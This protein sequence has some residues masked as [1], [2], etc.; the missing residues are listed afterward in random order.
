MKIKGLLISL[1]AVPLLSLSVAGC[2]ST[3]SSLQKKAEQGDTNAQYE[4]GMAYANSNGVPQ[5]YKLAV[6]WVRMAAEQGHPKAQHNLGNAYYNGQRV[7]QDY[8]EAVRWWRL[9]AEQGY[10]P[11]QYSMGVCSASGTSVPQDYV[12]AYAWFN[13][14]AAQGDKDAVTSR[15]ALMKKMTQTQIEEGQMLSREYEGKFGMK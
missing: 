12:Q 13:L 14:A 4:L 6:K 2:I 1:V 7:P 8:K 3:T 15:A 5:D 9:A 11:A 10:A